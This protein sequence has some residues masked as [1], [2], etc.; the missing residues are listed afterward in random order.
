MV[1]YVR[2]DNLSHILSFRINAKIA[3]SILKN[4]YIDINCNNECCNGN[5]RAATEEY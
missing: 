5:S 2:P 3:F 4:E 1:K